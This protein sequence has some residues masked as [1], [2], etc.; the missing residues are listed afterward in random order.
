MK[1]FLAV[2]CSAVLA[3]VAGVGC[4]LTGDGTDTSDGGVDAAS[5][6]TE[7]GVAADGGK[8]TACYVADQFLCDEYPNPTD[9]QVADVPVACSSRSGV[10]STPPACPT[11]GFGGKCTTG[12]SAPGAHVQRFYTGADLPYAQDFCV[13]TAHGVWSTTF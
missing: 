12:G 7:A 13:N 4:H 8:P 1:S 10:P 5:P 11:A 3:L 6:T 2:A 9:E